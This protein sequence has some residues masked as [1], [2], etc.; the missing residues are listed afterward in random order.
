[1][2][3]S[4]VPESPPERDARDLMITQNPG[5][6][7]N[8]G[9]KTPTKEQRQLRSCGGERNKKD[10]RTKKKKS[11]E[12]SGR[13]WRVLFATRRIRTRETKRRKPLRVHQRRT[14][15]TP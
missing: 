7:S 8:E 1:M 3:S 5:K 10:E 2:L 9:A 6:D 13:S 12:E 14:F 4:T 15:V 11:M